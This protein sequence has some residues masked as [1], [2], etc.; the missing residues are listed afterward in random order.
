MDS[1][2][3]VTH[4]SPRASLAI[5]GSVHGSE[6]HLAGVSQAQVRGDFRDESVL[7]AMNVYRAAQVRG[8]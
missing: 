1:H 5:G 2:I 6:L 4:D 7:Q 8:R 3:E